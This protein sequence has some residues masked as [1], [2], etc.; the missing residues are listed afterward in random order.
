MHK[1]CDLREHRKWTLGE[2]L[3]LVARCEIDGLSK[4]KSKDD[5]ATI[6]ALNEWDLKT[7]DWRKKIDSQRGAV[8][9]TGTSNAYLCSCGDQSWRTTPTSWQDGQLS[10]FWLELITSNLGTK[11]QSF[12]FCLLWQLCFA[13]KRERQ[14]QPRHFSGYL[15]FFAAF[16]LT[17]W[18]VQDYTPKEFATQINLNVK[19]SWG[20]LKRIIESCMKL[21]TGKYVLLKDP[22]KVVSFQALLICI[23]AC[24][25]TVFS[26]RWHL[27]RKERKSTWGWKFGVDYS[28]H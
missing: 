21:P 4:S 25:Q 14:F 28:S 16:P 12:P 8:F 19:N 6:K 18:K 24:N 10:Q 3:V 2:G 20:I 15:Y 5:L 23:P 22:E 1:H 13:T 9:A 7:T 27:C 11:I 26:S 17:N